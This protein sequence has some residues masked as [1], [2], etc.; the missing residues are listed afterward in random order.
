MNMKPLILC[1]LAG[2]L[3]LAGCAAQRAHEEGLRLL[4]QGELEP[5]LHKLQ[6]ATQLAPDKPAYRLAWL[7]ARERRLNALVDE[8]QQLERQQRL[9]EARERWNAVLALDA[10]HERA[11]A[12]LARPLP[13]AAPPRTGAASEP[14]SHAMPTPAEPLPQRLR[15]AYRK[16]IGL[17]FK[18]VSLQTI[19]EVIA[20]TSGLNILLDKDLRADHKASIY[21]KDSSVERAL[22]VLQLTQQLALRVIDDN[23]VLVYP[24]TAAK[25]KDYQALDVASFYLEH[26]EAKTVAATL[27]ALLKS[28]HVVVD[29]K[30]NLLIVRDSPQALQLA[31]KLVAL[32]DIAEPEV[33]L[34]VEILEVKRSRLLNL[35]LRWPDQLSLTPLPATSGDTLRLSDLRNLNSER[36]GAALGPLNLNLRKTDG[37]AN[38][39]ANPRIRARNREKARILIGERVPNIT[40]TS[41]ATGFVAESVNYVDVGLKL[42]VE[43]TVYLGDEVAIKV[44]LEV[45]NIISQLQT[46]QGSVAFQIGTR[47]AQTVLRLRDGESQLLAGLINDEDRRSANR[48]PGLGEL[49]VLGRLFGSQSDDQTKTE[50]VLSITPR[51]L[52]NVQPRAEAGTP[53]ATGTENALD[54]LAPLALMAPPAADA[55]PPVATPASQ[56]RSTPTPTPRLRWEGPAQ[57]QPGQAFQLQLRIDGVA[58]AGEWPLTLQFDPSVL[59]LVGVV[60]QARSRIDPSGQVLVT[61]RADATSLL[62]LNARALQHSASTAIRVMSIGATDSAGQPIAVTPSDFAL[63][64]GAGP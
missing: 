55:T 62:T 25:Q 30:L 46:K 14:P 58:S 63:R 61:S 54:T 50:I 59:Q 45:S 23:T 39:L 27:K 60:P 10:R 34:D 8:A 18:E 47:S 32:H 51:V 4:A 21:L 3:L 41:T 22:G 52:R 24:N 19:F 57:V 44:S 1:L 35:G 2:S 6:A 12:A 37:D 40:A 13:E 38:I 26:A 43:P 7:Q 53:F 20:R 42:E 56:T 28:Q 15:E 17:Q 11:L 16:P 36:T 29:E 9:G 49:P 31:R 48:V 64:I 33:L 5:G